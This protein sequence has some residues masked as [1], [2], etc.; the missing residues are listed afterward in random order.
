MSH[1]KYTPLKNVDE[2]SRCIPCHQAKQKRMSFQNN[3]YFTYT[4]FK[5]VYVDLWGLYKSK[6][7]IGLFS[8]SPLLAIIKG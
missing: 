4:I 2:I 7:I 8:F 5:L 6:T 3:E 1:F